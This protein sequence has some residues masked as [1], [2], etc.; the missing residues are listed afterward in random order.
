MVQE[1]LGNG[2]LTLYIYWL[3][4]IIAIKLGWKETQQATG[5]PSST[6]TS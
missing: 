4:K 6:I 3:A 2:A 5:P 1:W